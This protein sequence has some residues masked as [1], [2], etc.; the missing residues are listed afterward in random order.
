[1]KKKHLK[2]IVLTGL[3]SVGILGGS[4]YAAEVPV[5]I[6]GIND[7]HGALSTSGSATTPVE[8]RVSGAGK[9]ELL[10]AYLD[11]AEEAFKAENPNGTSIRVQAGDMVGASPANSGL[12]Q[13]EPTIKVLN[14]IGFEYGT[15]GNHEFDEGLEEF[16][17]IVTGTAPTPG[18]FNPI[19]DTYNREASKQEIVIGN[20]VD[21]DGNIPFGFKPYAVKT[22][23]AAGEKAQVGFVGV[24]TTDTPNLVLKK[25]HE[26]YTF[27]DEAETIVKYSKELR[28]NGVNAIVV[29]AHVDATSK[30]EVVSGTV[31]KILEKV[32]ALDPKN[33]VDV[34]FAGHNHQYTNGVL[35]GTRVVQSL[36]NGRAF[37]NVLGVL[38]TT[39]ND[40]KATPT[41]TVKVVAPTDAL[42]PDAKVAAI[43]KEAD[44]IVKTVTEAKIGTAEK[45]EAISRT[46]NEHLESPVAK[47]VTQAQLDRANKAGVGADFAITNNGGVRADLKVSEDGSITWGAAQAVQPFGNILQIV[48]MTGQQIYDVLNQQNEDR[49]ILQIAGMVYDYVVETEEK[50]GKQVSK[51]VVKNVYDKDGVKLDLAKTYKVVIN[52]F[53]FGGGD[54]FSV[55]KNA[56]LVGAIETD[57]EV[58]VGYIQDLEKAGKKV[59]VPALNGKRLWETKKGASVTVDLK[60]EFPTDKLVFPAPTGSEFVPTKPTTTG[61][62]TENDRVAATANAT[63]ETIVSVAQTPVSSTGKTLPKT[64]VETTAWLNVLGVAFLGFG[65]RRFRRE[66]K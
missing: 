40:F 10:S 23:E 64:G 32:N 52:D 13:D 12:L 33:S 7:L 36:A 24:L 14:E 59:T 20:V 11:Q 2:S 28:G 6:L 8:G 41:A 18:Q 56:K 9:A 54:G 46:N 49:S 43:I 5:Q 61:A 4:A 1:M 45:V 48:E 57:T 63:E 58:F 26:N 37:S 51:R 34:L 35:G 42:T 17:R 66:K 47:L 50:D 31:A 65:G 3:L 44:A 15:L 29:L 22:I 25:H 27:L 53:L 38:D 16:N 62:P 19:V 21:K 30:D 55:F 39:T 60:P